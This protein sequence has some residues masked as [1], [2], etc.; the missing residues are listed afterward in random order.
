MELAI[1]RLNIAAATRPISS[2]NDPYKMV[3]VHDYQS[4]KFFSMNPN[5]KAA[6]KETI[7]VFGRVYPE[8]LLEKYFVNVPA[9]MGFMYGVIK[10]FISP[11]TARKFHPMGSGANLAREFEYGDQLPKEYG[12]KGETLE[13]GGNKVLLDEPLDVE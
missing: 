1:R 3:Q 4:I 5:I 12:G 11:A 8:L 7:T 2:S 13:K 6:S 9:I 10:R